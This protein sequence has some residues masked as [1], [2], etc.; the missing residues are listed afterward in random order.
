VI[1]RSIYK[2][3]KFS[4]FTIVI[5]ELDKPKFGLGVV[6]INCKNVKMQS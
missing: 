2:S 3:K 4:S 1:F 6:F 5:R